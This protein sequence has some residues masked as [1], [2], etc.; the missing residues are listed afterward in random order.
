MSALNRD[1]WE[2]YKAEVVSKLDFSAVYR[3][4]R[5]AKPSGNGHLVGLC[6][7]HDDHTPSFGYSIKDGTWECFAGCGKGDVFAYLTRRSDMPFMDVLLELGDQVGV[8]RPENGAEKEQPTAYNYRDETGMLLFQVLRSP[9]KGF[10]QRRPNG[11]GGWINNLKGVCPVPYRLPDLIARPND[12]VFV[13]EGEKDADRLYEAGLLATTNS[14]GAGKWKTTHSVQLRDRDVVILPDNDAPGRDHAVKV[15]QYLRGVAASVCVVELPDLPA[16]GDVSDWLDAGHT[17]DELLGLVEAAGEAAP[18]SEGEVGRPQ[19]QVNGRQM[20]EIFDQT[21]E[22][23][24]AQNDPPTLFVSS[25]CL[26]RIVEGEYG[27][28]IQHLEEAHAYGIIT[29][30]AD[31]V[32]RTSTSIIDV[33]PLRE[34]SRHVLSTP[35]PGLPRLEAIVTTPVFDAQ[36]KL[37]DRPGYHQNGRLWLALDP[38]NEIA[39][40]P[41]SPSADELRIAVDLIKDHLICDFPFASASDRA[42][43]FAALLLPFVRRMIGGPTPIHLIESPTPGSGKSLL[44][45]LVTIVATGRSSESTTVTRNEEESR[46]KLTAI[47]IRG[48]PVVVID[49]V[50]GGIE[51]AQLASAITSD[52]WTDRILGKSEMVDIPNRALWM[53]TGNNLKLTMEIARRSVRIRLNPDEECPWQRTSFKHTPIRTWALANRQGLVWAI[54]TIVQAWLAAGRP[55]CTKTLGSFESWASVIGGMLQNAGID[56]FLEDT[57]E[58]YK[59]ADTE[60]GEWKAFVIAWQDRFGADPVSPSQL[61]TLAEEGSYVPFA[62]TG[63]SESARLARFGRALGSLRDRKFGDIQVVVSRNK[64]RRSNDYRLA[65]VTGDLFDGAKEQDQ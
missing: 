30:A 10:W 61:L 42:H 13:V 15:K 56:G 16:K 8:P 11:T 2:Q 48:R 40:I 64:K 33:K 1:R 65:N 31:W 47:L 14:G 19:I 54:L 46:K 22:I 20:Q 49:N 37:I 38:S 55:E 36:G 52:V 43:A 34:V 5:G 17:V 25:R 41:E 60:T 18:G 39:P 28:V 32:R 35:H 12:T 4:I 45:D 27:L 26:S 23:L 3:D 59:T 7:F 6:P 53:I 24:L 29:Y 9:G 44:A 57:E 51:S 62:R 63:S 58:F 21:W 50:Q